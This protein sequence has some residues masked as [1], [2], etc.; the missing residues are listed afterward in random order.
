[1]KTTPKAPQISTIDEQTINTRAERTKTEFRPKNS[2]KAPATTEFR[3]FV[4]SE[5]GLCAKRREQKGFQIVKTCHR[6]ETNRILP[7]FSGGLAAFFR[8]F[9]PKTPVFTEF[10][11]IRPPKFGIIRQG[12]HKTAPKHRENGP[13]FDERR[14]N[15]RDID[16]RGEREKSTAT[17][18][19]KSANGGAGRRSHKIGPKTRE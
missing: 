14:E 4:F 12:C 13:N 2:E 1:M 19:R 6:G 17:A 16:K 18:T 9:A 10:L 7:S 5:F 3:D 11:R 15:D 8:I